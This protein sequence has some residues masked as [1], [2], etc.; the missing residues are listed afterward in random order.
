MNYVESWN[1]NK[2]FNA[3]QLRQATCLKIKASQ[4]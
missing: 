1:S 3:K 4:T 2:S